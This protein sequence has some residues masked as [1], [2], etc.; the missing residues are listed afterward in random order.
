M[1]GRFRQLWRLSWGEKATMKR[2]MERQREPGV[3]P[4]ALIFS[5]A[6]GVSRRLLL[7]SSGHSTFGETLTMDQWIKP[8]FRQI[9]YAGFEDT[10]RAEQEAKRRQREEKQAREA[11]IQAELDE[12]LDLGLEESFPGSDPISIVQPP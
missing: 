10:G 1:F 9:A 5:G 2:P 8:R 11:R 7:S 3:I 6:G 12:A 4:A